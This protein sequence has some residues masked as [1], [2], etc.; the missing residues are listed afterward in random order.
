SANWTLLAQTPQRTTVASGFARDVDGF[1][2]INGQYFAADL[3]N[4]TVQR[5]IAEA[6][7]DRIAEQLAAY[8]S[9]QQVA[10]SR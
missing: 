6:L 1:N 8:F 7:A 5:R 3:E 2:I 10:A 4:D 9:R